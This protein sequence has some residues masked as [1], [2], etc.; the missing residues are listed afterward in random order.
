MR[1]HFLCSMNAV[2][3]FGENLRRQKEMVLAYFRPS[4][5]GRKSPVAPLGCTGGCLANGTPFP[6][7]LA[8]AARFCETSVFL[9]RSLLLPL[10]PANSLP[11][12][13]GATVM[14]RA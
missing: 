5:A 14:E 13:Y 6:R 8:T 9:L 2:T 7:V 1:I 3:G 4:A 12:N 10:L 11:R